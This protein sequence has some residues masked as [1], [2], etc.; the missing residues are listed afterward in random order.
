MSNEK[1]ERLSMIDQIGVKHVF[2][3]TIGDD[4][5]TFG[6]TKRELFAAMAMQA[7]LTGAVTKGCP[8]HEWLLDMGMA[9]KSADALLKELAK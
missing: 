5:S 8:A 9:V 2:P 6:L 7:I 3:I 1:L 4:A